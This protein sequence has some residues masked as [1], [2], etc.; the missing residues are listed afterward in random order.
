MFVGPPGPD[1]VLTRPV[2][3]RLVLRAV[4]DEEP[5]ILCSIAPVNFLMLMWTDK[6]A[7]GGT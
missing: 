1:D 3:H 2:W 7:A 6:D 5:A 4:T